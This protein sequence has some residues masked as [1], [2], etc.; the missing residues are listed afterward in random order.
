MKFSLDPSLDIEKREGIWEIVKAANEQVHQL[1][2]L[3]AI[4]CQCWQ[5]F[6]EPSSLQQLNHRIRTQVYF[7]LIDLIIQALNRPERP[8][9][10]KPY[11]NLAFLIAEL[12]KPKELNPYEKD[13]ILFNMYFN[14]ILETFRRPQ[15]PRMLSE[16]NTIGNSVYKE[17][18]LINTLDE[19]T[20]IFQENLLE[21]I[22]QSIELQ[23]PGINIPRDAQAT[24]WTWFQARIY[25]LSPNL[26]DCIQNIYHELM[27]WLKSHPDMIHQL[28]WS[29]FEQV[30]GELFASRGFD[31]ELT[32]R[33]RDLSADLIAV[34]KADPDGGTKHLIE[35]KRYK[36]ERRIGLNIVDKVLGAKLRANIEHAFL[37]T[38]SS[39]SRNV[40]KQKARL[41]ELRLGLMDG[42]KVKEWLRD[43]EPKSNGGIWLKRL[44]DGESD[45][46]K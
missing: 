7:D 12:E 13:H 10:L 41:D 24:V 25:P 9:N 14:I 22:I 21:R 36:E 15:I 2:M 6:I 31:V 28:N 44:R 38:T 40:N 42:Q 5:E 3:R 17:I 35:I 1:L 27:L 18:R 43:Y 19:Y 37:V 46:Q 29:V 39:F 30:V 34:K 11:E 33:I 23:Y 26:I 8:T 4:I 32:G 16:E 20:T 45:P